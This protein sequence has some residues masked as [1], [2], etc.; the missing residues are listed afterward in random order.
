MPT[1]SKFKMPGF[2]LR[3]S[4]NRGKDEDVKILADKDKLLP[5]I[6]ETLTKFKLLLDWLA[7]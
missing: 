7:N 4:F 6:A 1:L 3:R 2:H 5:E